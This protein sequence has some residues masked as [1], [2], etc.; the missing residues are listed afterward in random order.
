MILASVGTGQVVLFLFLFIVCPALIVFLLVARAR[1]RAKIKTLDEVLRTIDSGRIS[2]P[3]DQLQK[4]HYLRKEGVVSERKFKK[5][6][7]RI[8]S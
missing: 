3:L 4:L 2:G 6:K 8:L 5:E 1:Y 7:A